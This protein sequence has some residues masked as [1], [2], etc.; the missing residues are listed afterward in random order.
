MFRLLRIAVIGACLALPAQAGAATTLGALD[1]A[2]APSGSCAGDSG[3]VQG[4]ETGAGSYTVP[5]N[6]GV[7]TSW[8]HRANASAGRELALRVWRPTG[9]AGT[10]ILAA[11]EGFELL[12]PS[13]VNTFSTRLPV[14]AGDRLGL[15]VGNP[16]FP[17]G[18]GAS[19]AYPAAVGDTAYAVFGLAE[20]AAGGSMT[21]GNTY[22]SMRL[23]VTAQVEADA[24]ADG[25]GDESQD[26]CAGVNGPIDGCAAATGGAPPTD[27]TPPAADTT[28][29]LAQV[30]APRQK[31][32][33]GKV[34][35]SVTATEDSSVTITG[36]VAVPRTAKLHRLRKVTHSARA[37]QPLVVRLRLSGATR[38]AAQRALRK[39]RR[40]RVRVTVTVRDA[41]GNARSTRVT[42]RLKP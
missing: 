13:T 28:P 38:R 10:Y 33:R 2:G 26:L 29:P 17:I 34:R 19:C 36:T 14:T 30:S 9:T 12:S 15:R 25:F 23:N 40:V 31:I 18:G 16:G 5:A 4:A 6:G 8:S 41:A 39:G 35:V 32:A 24:D 20:P 1:P 3:W 21:L 7:I 11:G 22:T 42:L 27:G 37:N